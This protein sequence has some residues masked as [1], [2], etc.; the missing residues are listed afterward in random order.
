[1]L[2]ILKEEIKKLELDKE[3]FKEIIKVSNNFCKNL[4]KNLNQKKINASVFIGGSLAKKTLVK[5]EDNFYDVDVFVR[6][7]KK[8]SDKNISLL[9]E[10]VLPENKIKVHGSRDYFIIKFNEIIIEVIPVL[11]I[12]NPKEAKNV[13]DLSYFH[14][15]YILKKIKNKKSLSNEIKLS[16]IFCYA[17]NCY[18]AE[19]Y[20]KGFSGYAL[21][22]LICHYGSFLNF[23]TSISKNKGEK[24]IIDDLKFYKNKKEILMHMNESKLTS[25]IILIDPTCKERNALAGLS[26][27]TFQKF[28]KICIDFLKKPSKD[29]FK[30]KDISEELRKKFKDLKIISV[31]T[32]KQKGDIAGTKL[33]KFFNFFNLELE[34]E[35]KIKSKGSKKEYDRS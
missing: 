3:K 32:D 9:L 24:I 28:K 27:E 16:K 29:F 13:T 22:L 35:F 2:A 23:I 14:V 18:G 26:D 4:K 12:N 7:D 30:R 8:Y 19:S 33:K 17:N 5:T 34:K 25:P 31:E 20:I 21:E 11:K 1:M 15:N 10:S 6:F